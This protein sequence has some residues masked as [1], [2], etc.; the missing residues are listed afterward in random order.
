[1]ARCATPECTRKGG[2]GLFGTMCKRHAAY[3]AD[4]RDQLNR[5]GLYQQRTDQK[6]YQ[7]PT[8]CTPGCY[9]PRTRSEALCAFCRAS[10][11]TDDEFIGEAA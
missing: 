8:C 3:L 5:T 1:M 10:G 7:S 9:E 2:H 11:I 6:G 4:I